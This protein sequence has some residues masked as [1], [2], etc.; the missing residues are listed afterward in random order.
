MEKHI[1]LVAILNIVYRGL[2]VIGAFIL[3]LL[4]A[5]IAHFIRTLLRHGSFEPYDLPPQAA[6]DLVS[7]ILVIVGLS[8]LVVSA[9]GI[10]G[11]IGVLQKKEWGRIVLLVVSFL[12]L[13]HF[14]LGTALG[15]Y[16]IWALMKD[17]TVKIFNPTAGGQLAPPPA[18]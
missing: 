4:S 14:P 10:I 12:N 18:G 17:E 7:I 3:M 9:I 6:L 8:L 11:A 16:T 5:G 15:A 13:L 2:A 1:Q